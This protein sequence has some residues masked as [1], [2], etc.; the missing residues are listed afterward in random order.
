MG[1]RSGLKA[2]VKAEVRVDNLEDKD[3]VEDAINIS[4][5]RFI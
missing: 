4:N 3:K 5:T 1:V 2:R